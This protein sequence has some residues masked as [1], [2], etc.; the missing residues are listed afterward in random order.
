MSDRPTA[1]V[2]E[3]DGQLVLDDPV[4]LEVVRAIQKR[5]CVD[6][7]CLFP[8]RVEHFKERLLALGPELYAMV[9]INVDTGPGAALVEIMMPGHDWAPER[10]DG[11]TPYARGL[12]LREGLAAWLDLWDPDTAEKMRTGPGTVALV[13]DYSVAE[14]YPI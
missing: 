11:K 10:A 6:T 9:L 8:D 13:V 1:T 4:A 2:R 14:V 7:L 5:N 3:I 12:G